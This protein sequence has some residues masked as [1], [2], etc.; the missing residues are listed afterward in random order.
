MNNKSYI[1]TVFLFVVFLLTAT[2]LTNFIVDPEQVY[3]KLFPSNE[4]T[5]NNFSKEL[6]LSKYGIVN[7]FNNLNERDRK[8][9]LAMFSKDADSA[10][11]GSSHVMEIS[12]FA[13][14]KSLTK[15]CKSMINLGV[16][17]GT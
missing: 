1:K 8:K 2:T 9:S 10:T 12:S 15:Y 11:I 17:G 14:T 13:K 5:L 16:S 7:K 3:P 6:S 4:P